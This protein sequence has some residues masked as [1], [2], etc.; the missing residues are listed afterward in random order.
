MH[1]D[2]RDKHPETAPHPFTAEEIRE[3]SPPGRVLRHR[4]VAPG[5]P[6]VVQEFRVLKADDDWCVREGRVFS[7][8]GEALG[9]PKESRAAWLELQAHATFPADHTS[10]EDVKLELPAGTFDCMLYTVLDGKTVREYWFAR[11]LPGMPVKMRIEDDG[12]SR[13]EMELV[14]HRDG[15]E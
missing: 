11:E 5:K 8:E 1:R 14:E 12:K 2:P 13:M 10:I 9:E 7:E 15:D 4:I 3:G 6:T